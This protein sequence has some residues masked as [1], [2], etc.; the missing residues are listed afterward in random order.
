MH[1]RRKSEDL[2]ELFCK[3]NEF[4]NARSKTK[5]QGLSQRDGTTHVPCL[6]LACSRKM[7]AQAFRLSEIKGIGKR[8]EMK[9]SDIFLITLF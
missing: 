9:L 5:I 3:N 7:V 4:R 6:F 8:S 1:S 2:F